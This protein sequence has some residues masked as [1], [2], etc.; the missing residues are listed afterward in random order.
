MVIWRGNVRKLLLINS[1]LLTLC[2]IVG[3]CLLNKDDNE[4]LTNNNTV[5]N[6]KNNALTMM[7]ETDVDSEY[8][9]STSNEWPQEGY[10]FN[11]E[12]SA[13]ERGS[14]LSWDSETNSV[15]MSSISADKCYIYFDRYTTVNITNVTASNITNNSITL[16]AEAT[17]GENS[18]AT[19]YFSSN[20]GVSYEESDSN[21]YTFSNLNTGTEYN[22]RVYAVDTNGVSSN[23]YS[24]SE[25]TLTI[26]YLVDYI[27][28]VVYTGTDGDNG[29]YYHDGV[30]TYTNAAE[31][32]GDNSYR[33]AGANPN[34]YVCFG[35]DEATCPADNLYRIIGVFGDQVKLIKNTSLGNYYWG[36]SSTSSHTWSSSTFNTGTLNGTYLNGLGTTWSDMIETTNWIVG[37]NT[38]LNIVTNTSRKSAYAYEITSPATSDRYSAK[39]GLMYASDYGYAASPANWTTA[40]YNYDNSTN[41]SNNWLYLGDNEWTIT[42]YYGSLNSVL[43]VRYTGNMSNSSGGNLGARPT[44]YLKSNITLT[45]GDGSQNSP[46]R[47]ELG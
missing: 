31:E 40:L 33:Y 7:L 23:I 42:R 16:T 32:A 20:D 3:I 26:M 18:I 34:N 14:K 25:S 12:M 36:G 11:T 39:I 38:W 4:I 28:N 15:V 21:T 44:F 5:T 2:L 13:C 19:Y 8:E 46:F 47:I 29:L 27:K 41:T 43:L 45:S 22:F 17:A 6:N 37:G 30:G 9:V 35:S 10:I 1:V 24:L